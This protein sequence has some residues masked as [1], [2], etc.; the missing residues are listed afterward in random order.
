MKT[1]WLA[2]FG[3]FLSG[4]PLAAAQRPRAT[5]APLACH[6]GLAKAPLYLSARDTA[7]AARPS[8][9]L[10]ARQPA[11]VVGQFSPRWV[12]VRE[13]GF[14]YLTPTAAL[15]D[16][17]PADA[18]PLPLDPQ[19]QRLTYQGVVPV[20]DGASA[21]ALFTRATAWVA[22]AYPLQNVVVEKQDAA[23][24]LLV[25]RGAR[26]VALRQ[27]YEG[28]PRGTYAGVVRHRLSVYVKDGRYKYVLTDLEH[29]A[30]GAPHLRS[31][32][33]LEQDRANLFGYAGLGSGQPWQELRTDALR[34]ARQLLD[35]LQVAL[36]GQPVRR[37]A[38]A[39]DGF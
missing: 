32:G 29:D 19:T 25:L 1:V 39:P 11:A 28:V 35:S 18:L 20:P 38:P 24:G 26:L 3:L 34:D 15:A 9:Y 17:D 2:G 4:P 7:G 37:A 33:P 13:G 21:A 14:L 30:Q 36:T 31:G 16:Y 6:V 22:R 8:R 23:A 10:A 12:V 27:A 5:H